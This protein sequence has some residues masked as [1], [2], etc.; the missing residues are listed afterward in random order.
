MK[1]RVIA[2]VC[3]STFLSAHDAFAAIKFKRLGRCGEGL[4]TL[5]CECH[6]SNSRIWH[7]CHKGYYCHTSD[8]S[9]RKQSGAKTF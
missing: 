4:V 9:C 3:A 5:D 1:K 7:Y 2:I 6:A 8:G